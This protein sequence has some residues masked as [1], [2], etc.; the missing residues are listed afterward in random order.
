MAGQPTIG[1]GHERCGLFVTRN[2]KVDFRAPQRLHDI[3]VFL[4]GNPEDSFDS[5][6]LQSFNEEVRSFHLW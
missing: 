4:A 5:F 6:V 1:S 2:N 3:Q